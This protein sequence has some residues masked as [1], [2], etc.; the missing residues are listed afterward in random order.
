M[1]EEDENQ[2]NWCMGEDQQLEIRYM[3]QVQIWKHFTIKNQ[4]HPNKI[5]V[6]VVVKLEIVEENEIEIVIGNVKEIMNVIADEDL[7][8]EVLSEELGNEDRILHLVFFMITGKNLNKPS[9]YAYTTFRAKA[10]TSLP[11][12]HLQNVT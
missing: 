8:Q 6:I 3:I 5:I 11:Q 9:G 2:Q 1:E 12:C 4:H 7:D 10:F